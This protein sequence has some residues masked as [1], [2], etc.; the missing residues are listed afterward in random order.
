MGNSRLQWNRNLLVIA[1]V[2]GVVAGLA[3]AQTKP[4][5]AADQAAA[6]EHS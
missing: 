6:D 4:P 1:V 5:S 3:P 2:I